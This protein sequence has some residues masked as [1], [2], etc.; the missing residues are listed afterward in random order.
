M[1]VQAQIMDK[2]K[3]RN[4]TT[5]YTYTKTYYY[6]MFDSERTQRKT[7][8]IRF[9][10]DKHAIRKQSSVPSPTLYL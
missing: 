9:A 2:M 6:W 10:I 7:E 8:M 3:A 5:L 4:P 1:A